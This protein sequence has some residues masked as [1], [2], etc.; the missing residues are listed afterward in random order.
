MQTQWADWL[1]VEKASGRGG[2]VWPES[3]VRGLPYEMVLEI[4][5]DVSAGTFVADIY[6][7]VDDSLTSLASFAVSLG[8]YDANAGTTTLT[9]TLTALQTDDEP[10]A[11]A[12]GDGLAE[13]VFKLLYTPSGGTQRRAMGLVIPVSE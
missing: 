5:S 11:D 8:A 4:P 13:V 2:I 1:A 12:D 6:A 3:I 7:G 9:L 10:P